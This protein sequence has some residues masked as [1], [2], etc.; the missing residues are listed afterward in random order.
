MG[1][2]ERLDSREP[3]DL[4]A[5]SAGAIG[6]LVMAFAG[7][8]AVKVKLD[9]PWPAAV[10]LTV[11]ALVVLGYAAW[12]VK[13]RVT[14]WWARTPADKPSAALAQ[15]SPTAAD[16]GA[17]TP[18]AAHPE[19][20]AALT[21]TGA[22]GR[23]EVIRL[24][25]VSTKELAAGGTQYTFLL[26]PGGV[27][28]EVTKRL[29][30]IA[31][32][33]GKTRLHMKLKTSRRNEREV[34]LIK[35][36]DEP[37]SRAFTPPTR[38]EIREFSGVPLGHE[39]T[40]ELGG[41]P[42]FDKASMLIAGMSQMGKTTLLNGLI[43][44]LLIA[45]GDEFD[46]VLLDG[47]FVGLAPFADIALRYEASSDP[48][49]MEAIL[50]D[51]L[52]LVEKRYTEKK[53]AIRNRR[54]EP[55]F[56]PLFFIIDEAADFYVDNGTKAS[57]DRAGRV[58]E[59][60]RSLVAKAL[61]SGVS[62]IMLTQRPDKDAIPVNVR[63]QFQYRM[64]LYVDSEG[65]AK[66]ALGD[67]YFTTRAPIHPALLNPNIKGQAVLFAQGES[68]LIRGF[69]F[70]QEFMWE[71]IDEAKERRKARLSAVPDSPLKQAIELMQKTGVDFI[72][73]A[74]LAPALGIKET[75]DSVQGRKLAAL[76]K[77]PRGKDEKGVR[78]YHLADLKAAAMSS[79]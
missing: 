71:V 66:V 21:R 60:S 27:H 30:P 11:G 56:R 23:D 53:E 22:I 73:S 63:A 5:H 75:T 47:K 35:L 32:M 61:E 76:L 51:L 17:E 8:T 49:V 77:A 31:S 34:T 24:E 50:D 55:K 28:E 45:Y 16:A 54:P 18:V 44:C 65:A 67:S 64:C 33:L 26:P 37:F 57:K 1:K 79:S 78:G 42:T 74:Q 10:A 15:E 72:P 43:T 58:E 46:T 39:V 38:Q 3:D 13:A 52:A 41:V 9:V 7:L 12:W 69:N 40:G 20:T 25:D 70:P 62:V 2:K 14:R 68:T 19:L 29:G 4:Y 59:K 48:A 36:D 6:V